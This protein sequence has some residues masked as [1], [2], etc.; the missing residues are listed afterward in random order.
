[1]VLMDVRMPEMDG[2]A[3]TQLICQRFPQVKVLVLSTFDDDAPCESGYGIFRHYKL[4]N[5]FVLMRQRTLT[6]LGSGRLVRQSW[7]L[8]PPRADVLTYYLLLITY[9]LLLGAGV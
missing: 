5:Q 3:A 8:L 9:Y 7:R 2:V 1:M 6:P 4:F